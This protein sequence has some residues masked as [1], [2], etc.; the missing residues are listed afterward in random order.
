MAAFLASLCIGLIHTTT[1][2]P[3]V[4]SP[5]SISVIQ[6]AIYSMNK[7]LQQRTLWSLLPPAWEEPSLLL[8]SKAL[9]DQFAFHTPRAFLR[10][11]KIFANS[12]SSLW[13]SCKVTKAKEAESTIETP[14][15]PL[16]S[17][18]ETHLEASWRSSSFWVALHAAFLAA[19]NLDRT[20]Q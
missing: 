1:W 2:N 14:M 15:W 16:Y 8:Q 17:T 12:F 3:T 10:T 20:Q 18:I 5:Q 9:R 6:C 13:S 11:P 4:N 7:T 19:L